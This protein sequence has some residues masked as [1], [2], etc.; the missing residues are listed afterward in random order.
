MSHAS[1]TAQPSGPP[2]VPRALR[3]RIAAPSSPFAVER[4]ERGV[5]RLR[6]AGFEIASWAGVRREGHPYLNGSDDERLAELEDALDSDAD[7]VWLARGGY[8]LTRIID[9]VSPHVRS[10]Q[11][12]VVGFSDATALLARLHRAGW[13]TLH[14][15][16]ITTIADEDAAAFAQLLT[17][18]RGESAALPVGRVGLAGSGEG[19]LVAP[20]FAANLCVLTHLIGTASMPTLEGHIVLLEEVGERP[21]RI[22]RMLTQ[23]LCSGALRGVR[24]VVV[25][26]LSGC[27]EPG[28]D[29]QRAPAPEDV[30]RERLAAANIPVFFGAAFGHAHPN[31]AIPNGNRMCIAW[32]DQSARFAFEGSRPAPS[33]PPR[34]SH[35]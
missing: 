10:P 30:F 14:G 3:V 33:P 34:L 17:L 8:G 5:E 25:G 32:Q 35:V 31:Y 18:L 11:T 12:R 6:A 21:Y 16:L 24:A 9:R 15:P 4:L 7:I 22:D 20:A 26:H 28:A 13:K 1:S 27:T 19:E 23:L 2:E 29:A